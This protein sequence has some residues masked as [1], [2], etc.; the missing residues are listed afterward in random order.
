M[1]KKFDVVIGNPPYQEEATGTGTRDTPVYHLFMDAAYEVAQKAV[2]ITPAR[3]LFNAGLTPKSWNERML[4]DAHLTVPIYVPNSDKLFPGTGIKGGIAVTY[5]DEGRTVEPIGTF[6]RS[7][8]VNDILHKV[9]SKQGPSLG[10]EVASSSAFRYTQAMHDREPNA[11]ALMSNSSQFKVNTN[12]FQQLSFIF[13]EQ[14]PDDGQMYVKTLGLLNNKRVQRWIRNDYITG[15]ANFNAHKVVVSK[16]NGTGT[17][18]ETLA[19][20]L[21]LGPGIATTQSFIAIGC[22]DAEDEAVACLNYLK[23]K[24]ARAL[25]GVLK[26]TQDNPAKVWKHVPLQDFTPA[27]DI[28]WSKS[29]PEIDGQLYKKYGLS[30][31]EIDFIETNVKAMV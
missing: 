2:L 31:S 8:E 1:D 9:T 28:D 6:S 17:F 27:S 19:S 12:A 4:A 3:F 21:A 23:T 15:P 20:P 25:L 22:F 13:H 30:A 5:R 29:V 26:T 16:A 18:G 24:F 7:P 14:K 10:A 11:S